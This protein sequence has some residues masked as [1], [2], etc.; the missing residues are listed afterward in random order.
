MSILRE[1][2][3]KEPPVISKQNYQEPAVRAQPHQQ[4]STPPAVPPLPPELAR[5]TSQ[6]SPMN[7]RERVPPQPPPKPE[8]IPRSED[9]A[10]V[11]ANE[12]YKQPPPPPDNS[13]SLPRFHGQP[14][15]RISQYIPPNT[16]TIPATSGLRHDEGIYRAGPL[17]SPPPPPLPGTIES[18]PPPPI[19]SPAH[20]PPQQT[21]IIRSH[22]PHTSFS[23]VTPLQP[24]AFIP[25]SRPSTHYAH[26]AHQTPLQPEQPRKKTE[27]PDL[28][29]SPF[30]LEHLAPSS[31]SGIAPPIPP[32]PE[33]DALLRSLSQALTQNLQSNVSQ[34]NSGLQA[35]QSQFKALYAAMDTLQREHRV[36]AGFYSDLHANSAILQLS[37]NRANNVIADAKARSSGTDPSTSA[38]DVPDIPPID[39]VLV[40]PTIVG[41]QLYDLIAD[42]RGIQRAIYAL[43]AGLVKGRVGIET[44]TRLTRG[45]AREAFLKRALVKKAAKGMGLIL[46]GKP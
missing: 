9:Q 18:I 37:L 41:K 25:Y 22:I 20:L 3:A 27:T 12:R 28:L 19:S 2:F 17:G 21:Q 23:Q 34:A 33:K 4:R 38:Q 36:L 44:W 45:L 31:S 6:I 39:E 1:I 40:A 32:N 43:Q 10:A 13:Q 5:P 7:Y 16:Q 8:K 14:G 26:P 30:D 46:D 29:T 11:V 24:Q 35:L 42:E 15:A